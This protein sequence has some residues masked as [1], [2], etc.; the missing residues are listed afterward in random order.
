LNYYNNFHA[1]N[2]DAGEQKPTCTELE[3]KYEDTLHREEERVVFQRKL[4]LMFQKQLRAKEKNVFVETRQSQ[5]RSKAAEREMEMERLLKHLERQV[6]HI[7][8]Q[9]KYIL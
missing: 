4:L 6:K 8:L 5:Q 1:D 9:C 3:K 2:Y 7:Y